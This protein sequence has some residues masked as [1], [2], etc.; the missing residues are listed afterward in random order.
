V[1]TPLNAHVSCTT[2]QL[3]GHR[4]KA[5]AHLGTLLN[6]SQLVVFVQLPYLIVAASKALVKSDNLHT[7][8]GTHLIRSS[9]HDIDDCTRLLRLMCSTQVAV[10]LSMLA[11]ARQN[12]CKFSSHT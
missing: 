7:G 6:S 4:T 12:A 5:Q 10:E 8:T 3:T 2:L 9:H 1:P 11:T